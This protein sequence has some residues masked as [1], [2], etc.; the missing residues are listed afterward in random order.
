M[1]LVLRHN[2][3][4]S[5]HTSV[6]PSNY[7]EITPLELLSLITHQMLMST[8]LITMKLI[9]SS[10]EILEADLGPS[11]PIYMAMEVQVGDVKRGTLS[12]SIL[13]KI[14]IRT[15][16]SGPVHGSFTTWMMFLLEWFKRLTPWVE[17]FPLRL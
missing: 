8:E 3:R 2:S 17:I 5:I 14:S 13:L 6:L 1:A 7:Q 11:K 9:L 16:F 15:V 12:G 10:W 4:I